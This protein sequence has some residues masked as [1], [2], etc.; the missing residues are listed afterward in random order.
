MTQPLVVVLILAITLSLRRVLS[1]PYSSSTLSL[2]LTPI[3]GI[4][5]K[6]KDE[7][8]TCLF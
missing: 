4:L 1:N 8:Q 3:L 2:S 5:N 6:R 7:A